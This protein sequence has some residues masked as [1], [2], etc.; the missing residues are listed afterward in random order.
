MV[1]ME[2]I[3]AA[4]LK[5]GELALD[6]AGEIYRKLRPGGDSDDG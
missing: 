5:A 6:F 3:L 4:V 1:R 2:E